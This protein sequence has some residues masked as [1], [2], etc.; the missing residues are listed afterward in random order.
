MLKD[1]EATAQPLV[2]RLVSDAE[3][4][5]A[6]GRVREALVLLRWAS[7]ISPDGVLP[8]V[9][10]AFHRLRAARPRDAAVPNVPPPPRC[11]RVDV[12]PGADGRPSDAL[13]FPVPRF[14]TARP[15][16]D[17]EGFVPAPRALAIRRV[18]AAEPT[19]RPT[20]VPRRAALAPVL[21]VAA[22]AAALVL[23]PQGE[24]LMARFRSFKGPAEPGAVALSS[25]DPGR[26]LSETAAVGRTAPVLL[27]RGRAFLALGDTAAALASLDSAAANAEASADEARRAAELLGQLPGGE[28]SAADAYL[29]A[30][31]AGLGREH[32]DAAAEA[33]ERAGRSQQARRLRD[34]SEQR[35]G[36]VAP[37][38]VGSRQ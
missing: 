25:G 3:T 14:P 38:G 4:Q 7:R 19:F 20:P 9:L 30:F 21:L 12:N 2:E 27:L 15:V 28:D 34:L 11:A 23:A 37:T 17:A 18:A 1:R 31:E 26:A 10:L 5:A 22:A 6:A 36:A 32:W 35:A 24:M 13:G 16:I 29:R 8:V 33:L